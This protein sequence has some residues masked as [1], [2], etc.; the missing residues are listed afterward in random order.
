MVSAGAVRLTSNLRRQTVVDG[1]G[2]SD[3]YAADRALIIILT[4]TNPASIS[5]TVF[6]F[7]YD[8]VVAVYGIALRMAG[9]HVQRICRKFRGVLAGEMVK[10][11]RGLRHRS[12][13]VSSL[14]T[15]GQRRWRRLFPVALA[16]GVDPAYMRGLCAGMLWLLYILP[17]C[18]RSGG[19]SGLRPFRHNPA[20]WRFVIN[21]SFILPRFAITA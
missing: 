5:K 10:S 21:H 12:A 15:P 6:S 19:D 18:K 8:Y 11:I 3:V 20:Y 13:V 1:A 17:T 4:K 14:L 7:Q 16:I 9:N 2:H